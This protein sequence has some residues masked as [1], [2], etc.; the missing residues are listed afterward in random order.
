MRQLIGEAESWESEG[1]RSE[2]IENRMRRRYTCRTTLL[3]TVWY[4]Q[5]APGTTGRPEG[6]LLAALSFWLNDLWHMTIC[7]SI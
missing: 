1:A 7:P 3:L 6:A 4:S 5:F 2:A